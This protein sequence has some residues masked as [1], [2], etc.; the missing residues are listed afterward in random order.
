MPKTLIQ[1]CAVV[2]VLLS[3]SFTFA[4]FDARNRVSRYTTRGAYRSAAQSILSRPTVI[5]YLALTD[6]TGSGQIDPSRNYFTQVRPQLESRRASEQ[7]QQ[8]LI[9]VQREVSAIRAAGAQRNQSA[10]RATGHPT[11]FNYLMQY[12]PSLA[13][14]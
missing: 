8:S 11:R 2:A 14:R 3:Y 4:Q 7:Q 12:Y 10:A 13:R 9:A 6:L 5:P 1:T